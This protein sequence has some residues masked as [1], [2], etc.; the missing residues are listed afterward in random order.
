MRRTNNANMHVRVY[1][2]EGTITA[3]DITELNELDRFHLVISAIERLPQTGD[4][5][6]DVRDKL[7]QKLLEQRR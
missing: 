2:E 7:R 5:G 3:I 6:C 4:R 1:M